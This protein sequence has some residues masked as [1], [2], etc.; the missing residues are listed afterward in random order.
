MAEDLTV[1]F[2]A[3]RSIRPREG[4]EGSIIAGDFPLGSGG[5]FTGFHV[6][7]VCWF[8]VILVHSQNSLTQIDCMD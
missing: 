5:T 8:N 6:N 2:E 1:F 4:F 7:I 3:S